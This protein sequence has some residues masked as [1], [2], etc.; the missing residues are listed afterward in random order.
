[1]SR[2]INVGPEPEGQLL[3]RADILAWVK[4][5]SVEQWKKLRPHLTPVP[6]A[7]CSRPYYRK[8]E[9]KTKLVDPIL[10]DASR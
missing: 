8:S 1:M 2:S 9:I 4:G 7:G 5:Y 10:R 3:Q 6:V